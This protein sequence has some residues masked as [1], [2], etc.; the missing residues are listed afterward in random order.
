MN[1]KTVPCYLPIKMIADLKKLREQTGIS[2]SEHIRN[3]ITA[4]L[5]ENLVK[6]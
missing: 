4:Y 3:A 6:E 2:F 5:K 1:M